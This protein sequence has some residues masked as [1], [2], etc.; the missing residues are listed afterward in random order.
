MSEF[1][2]TTPAHFRQLMSLLT[3]RNLLKLDALVCACY[4]VKYLV[5][6]EWFLDNSLLLRDNATRVLRLW[7]LGVQV[8]SLC[9]V[10]F[11][12]AI[13]SLSCA[14]S[15][16]IHFL[17]FTFLCSAPSLTSFLAR[18]CSFSMDGSLFQ[19]RRYRSISR[20]VA[21]CLV[22]TW[23]CCIL[24]V[25]ACRC[26]FD[27]RQCWVIQHNGCVVWIHLFHDCKTNEEDLTNE[28]Q[29]CSS[30]YSS[31]LSLYNIQAVNKVR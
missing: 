28:K 21:Q 12:T 6:P 17:H 15:S 9:L 22:R 5:F 3:T 20:H 14:S 10:P 13:P 4:G 19:R 1:S 26:D 2:F 24:F 8:S 16:F 31:P 11:A 23:C 29:P 27:V 18:S 7:G 30:F 25:H